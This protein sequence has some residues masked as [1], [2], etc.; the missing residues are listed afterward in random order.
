MTT[1]LPVAGRG[2][3]A[4]FNMID[5]PLPPD[6]TPPGVPNRVVRGNYFQALGIPLVRGRYFTPE[7]RLGGTQAVIVSE[8]LARRF[9]PD[10]D[11]IGRRIYMGAPDN[12]VVPESEIVAI[13][14]DVKQTG[15]DE[16]Q[17]EAV[18]VPHGMVPTITSFTFAIRTATD[19][20]SLTAAARAV[21]RRMDPGVPLVRVQTMDAIIGRA[22]APARSSMLLVA[23]FAAVALALALI[24]VF[25]VLS[26]TV[27]QRKTEIGIRM[28][29]GATAS[30]VKLLVLGQG[31]VPVVAG[32][33]AGIGGALLLTRFMETLLFGV[34]PTDPITFVTVALLL[35]AVAA[36]A[37]Y[38]PARRA[39]RTDPATVLR[40]L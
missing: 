7:D 13:V 22:V 9:W 35:F 39:T 25:G 27:N 16:E 2:N 32:M 15:L 10:G 28:A 8:S 38:I 6:Q 30:N 4:W 23:L 20:A 26:Y 1:T 40:S 21:F 19:P 33:A 37:S 29:L 31:M 3:G 14:G 18:Y 12:R 24:G 36:I 5:R 34:T 17:P 11:A